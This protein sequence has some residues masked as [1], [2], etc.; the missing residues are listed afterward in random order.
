MPCSRRAVTRPLS[1]DRI[2]DAV[3]L[4]SRICALTEPIL[5]ALPD[6][7]VGE[8]GSQMYRR[9]VDR[10]GLRAGRAAVGLHG[11][12]EDHVRA[13]GVVVVPLAHA[14]AG[15]RDQAGLG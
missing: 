9:H 3:A 10:A 4:P 2:A 6:I 14:G 1:S 15:L 8:L 5:S 11:I 7:Y 13:L 12:G